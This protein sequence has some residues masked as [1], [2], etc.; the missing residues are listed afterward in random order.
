M[1]DVETL[2]SQAKQ[3]I[4]ANNKAKARELLEKAISLDERHENA[5]ILMS[6]VV[7]SLEDKQIC[8]ENVLAINPNNQRAQQGLASVNA[9]LGP[10]AAAPPAN[11]AFA[12]T[13]FDSNP[14]GGA[15]SS[16]ADPWGAEPTSSADSNPFGGAAGSSDPW[17]TGA[18]A[19]PAADNNPFGGS[20]G[21]SD[22]WG[23]SASTTPAASSTPFGGGTSDA[24]PFGGST[25]PDPW[26]ADTAAADKNPFGGSDPF[27]GAAA[28]ANPWDQS[29]PPAN[30]PFGGAASSASAP[31]SSSADPWAS[32]GN[33][34]AQ[35]DPFQPVA[36]APTPSWG[37]GAS[38]S[39]PTT[40]SFDSPSTPTADGFEDEDASEAGVPD[41]QSA[42]Q[43]GQYDDGFDFDD[44][45]DLDISADDFEFGDDDIEID[46]SNT[47]AFAATS[48][49]ATTTSEY[50]Q[51]IP[52]AIRQKAGE[53]SSGPSI[54]VVAGL[55]LLNVLALVGVILAVV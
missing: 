31:A 21:S 55:G 23:T 38:P 10:D 11:D 50:Y 8:L 49:A 14:F 39:D 12:G 7:E 19:T 29:T 36:P 45:D 40:R 5:W 27:G 30:D 48:I 22:P 53:T 35:N 9:N 43:L 15:A 51:Y 3:H 25:S 52:E 33:P 41:T 46:M 13:G 20:A 4:Q 42:M 47:G 2:V 16:G 17:G 54:A 24:N 44:A 26:G 34:A 37:A 18:S 32:T 6:T 28:S 1:S